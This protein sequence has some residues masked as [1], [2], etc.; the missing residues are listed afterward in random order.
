MSVRKSNCT[1]YYLFIFY[2]NKIINKYYYTS[3]SKINKYY[4]KGTVNFPTKIGT[5]K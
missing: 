5:V 1:M 4:Y 2:L 3:S